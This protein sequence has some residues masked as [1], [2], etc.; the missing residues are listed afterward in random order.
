MLPFLTITFA[1][2]VLAYILHSRASFVAQQKVILICSEDDSTISSEYV[3]TFQAVT[4]DGVSVTVNVSEGDHNYFY[5]NQDMMHYDP[6]AFPAIP[7]NQPAGYEWMRES[8]N[9]CSVFGWTSLVIVVYVIGIFL[10]ALRRWLAPIFFRVYEVRTVWCYRMMTFFPTGLLTLRSLYAAPHWLY[11][12]RNLF[13]NSRYFCLR[14][15][16]SR[17][18]PSVSRPTMRC[19]RD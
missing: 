11:F 4:G 13:G 19:Q 16:S 18:R 5:C 6:P 15:T 14:A 8:Q 17:S 12:L 1:V 9:F 3:G 2:S 7:S 10:N